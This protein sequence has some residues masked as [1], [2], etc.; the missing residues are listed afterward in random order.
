MPT[1]I[2]VSDFAGLDKKSVILL[3]Q[4]RT[5]DK[6]RLE[7]YIGH[8]EESPIICVNY[9]IIVSLGIDFFRRHQNM[10]VLF[11]EAGVGFN[12]PTIVKYS[13]WRMAYEWKDALYAC[14]N[15]GEAFAPDEIKKPANKKSSIF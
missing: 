14:L 8:L 7:K 3:E 4:I 9:A 10:R 12:T 1:H 2:A 5:I 13:F 11:L 15:Y 6:Q